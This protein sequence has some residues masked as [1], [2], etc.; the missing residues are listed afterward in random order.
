MEEILIY[1]PIGSMGI[2][3]K[4]IIEQIDSVSAQGILVR[5]NSQG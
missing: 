1:E 2:T 4:T 5:I 3:A